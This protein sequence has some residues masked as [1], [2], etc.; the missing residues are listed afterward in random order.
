MPHPGRPSTLLQCLAALVLA[1]LAATAS[2][3]KPSDSYLR[4]SVAGSQL[5]GQWD[6]ALRDLD[7]ALGLDADQDGVI[8]WGEVRR[9]HA[10]IAAY[11][12]ARLDLAADGERCVRAVDD[13][14]VDR[15]SDGSYAVIAFTARCPLPPRELD[16]RYR[17][18]FDLDPQHR[19]LAQI[20]SDGTVQTAIFS[21]DGPW[22]HFAV[23]PVG[24]EGPQSVISPTGLAAQTGISPAGLAAQS[25]ISP[26]AEA[27]QAGAS[28]RVDAVQ[29][30]VSLHVRQAFR[31]FAAYAGHGIHHIWLGYDHILFL[32][33]LLIPAVLSRSGGRWQ[34]AER[35]GSSF[36][37]VLKVVTA[38]TV[39]HSLTLSAAALGWVSL[40]SRMVESAI[41]ISV[42][43][44]AANN[45]VPFAGDRRWLLA[46]VF[47]LV[48]GFGFASVLSD[49]GLP[50]QTLLVAL[51]GFN[52]GVAVGQLA[53]V[54]LFMPIAWMARQ[55]RIYLPFTVYGASATIALLA[56]TWLVERAL[57]IKLIS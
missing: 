52:C 38:F 37:D 15:H 25:D 8:S 19:G 41:A 17:L 55:R 3:H 43:I 16:I 33:S 30:G 5:R 49:L 36:V 4:I 18:L 26:R 22:Q 12:L 47:G 51:L 20:A 28:P 34:P 40:P 9:R 48:H 24:G 32:L 35:F 23:T 21:E 56:L 11:A 27:V 1:A 2:A 45:L 44:A 29:P 14:L 57:N 46:F 50:Q 53:V 13:Q 31:Q 6:I 54:A 7:F 42:I 39:A 10:D